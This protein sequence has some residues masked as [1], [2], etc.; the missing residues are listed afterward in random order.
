VERASKD[1]RQLIQTFIEALCGLADLGSLL[2]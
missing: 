1:G 2:L